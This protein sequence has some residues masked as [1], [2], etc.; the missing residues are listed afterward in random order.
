MDNEALVLDL[1]E[2]IAR[3]PRVYDDVMAA[4]RTSC[5]QLTIWEDATDADLVRVSFGKDSEKL[6]VVTDEGEKFL[7]QGGRGQ[8]LTS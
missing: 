4:W 3:R 8:V 5:P 1:V 6:V 7:Q 2:W